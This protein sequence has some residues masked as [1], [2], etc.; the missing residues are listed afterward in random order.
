MSSSVA[1]A[2]AWAWIGRADES[3]PRRK[4]YGSSSAGDDDVAVLHRLAKPF[5][6][7]SRKLEHLIQKEN[8]M[9]SEADFT[10]TWNPASA[11]QA[12]AR[13]RMMGRTKWAGAPHDCIR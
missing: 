8:S 1:E 2:A 12:R 7:R 13:Y 10:G 3:E 5:E 4:S 11:D 6:N 9:M